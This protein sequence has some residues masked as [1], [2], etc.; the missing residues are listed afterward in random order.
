MRWSE[1]SDDGST[2]TLPK[3]RSKNG[4]AHTLPMTP[5]MTEIVDSIPQRER[6]DLL[7]GRKHGFTGWSIGKR[8]LDEKIGLPHWTHRDIRRSVSTGMNDIGIQPHIVEQVLNHQSGH[9]RGVAGT[10]NRSVYAN[11][12]RAALALWSD[13]VRAIVD[14]GERKVIPLH[15][16]AS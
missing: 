8:A 14:G 1:F 11:E 6:F 7:F 13:H 10:Y 15:A 2:W 4:K 12:V 5:V 9:R 16:S 3:E